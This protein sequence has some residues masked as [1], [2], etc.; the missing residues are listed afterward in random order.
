MNSA[1][2]WNPADEPEAVARPA[3]L[4]CEQNAKLTDA[5]RDLVLKAQ[6]PGTPSHPS[7]VYTGQPDLVEPVE[8]APDGVLVGLHQLRDLRDRPAA[9]RGHQHHRPPDPHRT[10][11]SP[12]N[13]PWQP[14]SLLLGQPADSHR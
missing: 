6:Q 2:L 5:L 7:R 3:E 11:V 8:H 9:R 1:S 12:P 14:L 4:T 10:G 13:D